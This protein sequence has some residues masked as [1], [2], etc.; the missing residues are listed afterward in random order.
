MSEKL[1]TE[2]DN[3][4]FDALI[5]NYIERSSQQS[6]EMPSASFFKLLFARATE[7]VKKTIE[8]EGKIVD[9]QLMLSLPDAPVSDLYVQN[10]QIVIGEQQIV[11][12]LML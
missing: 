4:E 1:L 11:V 10:N 3:D 7:R 6:G 9:G 2:M 8:I 5:D 12:K